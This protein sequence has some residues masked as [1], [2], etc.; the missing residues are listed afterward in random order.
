[1]KRIIGLVTIV[2]LSFLSFV[3]LASSSNA[4]VAPGIK[5]KTE[6]SPLYL[7]KVISSQQQVIKNNTIL[8]DHY[9]HSSHYSHDSHYSHYSSRY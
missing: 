4:S 9:S 6:T 5:M 2:C 8:A 3:G 7:N 1:V